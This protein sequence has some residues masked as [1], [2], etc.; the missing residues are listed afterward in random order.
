MYL[1]FNNLFISQDIINDQ[2]NIIEKMQIIIRDTSLF[3][4]Q[5]DF[6][7]INCEGVLIA[8][9]KLE[10]AINIFELCR[11]KQIVLEQALQQRRDII[12]V[13]INNFN[14]SQI[15]NFNYDIQTIEY[16]LKITESNMLYAQ[17]SIKFQKELLSLK[18]L[19]Q[20]IQ[21]I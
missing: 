16:K 3:I 12:N 11:N 17:N 19:C 4:T 15:P 7:I 21:N 14:F 8:N 2:T 20:I 18:D 5:V 10:S 1:N 6:L 13:L 9:N